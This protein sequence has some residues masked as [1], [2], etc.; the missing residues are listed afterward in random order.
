MKKKD[1]EN[2]TF[3]LY[4]R[5][6]QKNG[7]PI[8]KWIKKKNLL[9]WSGRTHTHT[10]REKERERERLAHSHNNTHTQRIV[11]ST[12]LKR[13]PQGLHSPLHTSP[14][15]SIKYSRGS[16][17]HS[18]WS[19]CWVQLREEHGCL[20]SMAVKKPPPGL[21]QMGCRVLC[22]WNMLLFFQSAFYFPAF[23]V[24][25]DCGK[26]N[27]EWQLLNILSQR[28]NYVTV[29]TFNSWPHHVM[30]MSS[31]CQGQ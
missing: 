27:E 14:P 8:I 26:H 5:A 23:Y 25:L 31:L 7:S 17:S 20:W 13:V 1:T 4:D 19:T 24:W 21:L 18:H 6:T 29:W 9:Y 28:W 15:H 30:I 10:E 12:G 11:Y 2:C 16:H 22:F 3:R